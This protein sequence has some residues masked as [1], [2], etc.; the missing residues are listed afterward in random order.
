MPPSTPQSRRV[1]PLPAP[2]PPNPYFAGPPMVPVPG[3]GGFPGY[4]EDPGSTA[5]DN[6]ALIAGFLQSAK[7]NVVGKVT[8]PYELSKDALAS[9]RAGRP[10]GVYADLVEMARR[11]SANPSAVP[12]QVMNALK[13]QFEQGTSSPEEFGKFLG[14]NIDPTNVLRSGGPVRAGIFAGERSQ[15]WDPVRAAERERLEALGNVSDL[16]MWRQT[17]TWRGPDGKLRQEIDDSGSGLTMPQNYR[18]GNFH[19]TVGAILHHPE[20]YRAYPWM[21]NLAVE[22]NDRGGGGSATPLTGKIDVG[23]NAL[24]DPITARSTLIHE[25]QH[26]V[27]GYE[28][29]APGG[30]PSIAY[31]L[32]SKANARDVAPAFPEK[33]QIDAIQAELEAKR[34]ELSSV[35]W[36][37]RPIETL[38]MY[39]RDGRKIKPR[40]FM[41]AITG[42]PMKYW[43]DHGD[44]IMAKIGRPPNAAKY[45]AA[46]SAW[47]MN[48]GKELAAVIK[49]KAPKINPNLQNEIDL[50][51]QQRNQIW[52]SQNFVENNR[53][54]LDYLDRKQLTGKPSY[55]VYM[56]LG[57]EAEARA[58]QARLF[59]DN[60]MRG[61][62]VPSMDYDVPPGRTYNALYTDLFNVPPGTIPTSA[63]P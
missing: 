38:N 30:N 60:L 32:A 36:L 45:P 4:A 10:Q 51:M 28:H 57:G 55:D 18:G 33:A 48:A 59:Y 17:G 16:D 39:A 31:N 53:K 47:A 21:R 23:S 12:G 35:D 61:Q 43:K 58:S 22:F 19:S 49:E 14:S 9:F 11:A 56:A 46:Y 25:L 1:A 6:A 63:R 7:D 20:L 37:N 34:R 5:K 44:Q 42:S 52:G 26:G 54:F 27:Q 24:L 8:L 13:A 50:L 29:F 15:T 3:F 62:R 41:D 2:P 40:D